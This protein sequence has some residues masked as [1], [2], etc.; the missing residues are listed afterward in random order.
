MSAP[1]AAACASFVQIL[2]VEALQCFGRETVDGVESELD[3]IAFG[4]YTLGP[5]RLG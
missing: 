5:T 2:L 3:S 4:K 1:S